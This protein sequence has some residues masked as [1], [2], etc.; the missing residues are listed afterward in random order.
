LEIVR[1]KKRVV[2][3]LSSIISA[4]III[5]IY[6]ILIDYTAYSQDQ[7]FPFLV[8]DH[9]N[10]KVELLTEGLSFPTSMAFIDK[11]NTLVLE[12]NSGSVRLISDGI[13]RQKPILTLHVDNKGERGL[14]GIA[15]LKDKIDNNEDDTRNNLEGVRSKDK[16]SSI[17]YVFLY[18][19]ESENATSTN[20]IYRYEWD[21]KSLTNPKLI[22]NFL[23]SPGLYH[24]GGKMLIGPRDNQLYVAIGDLNEPNSILQNYKDGK[25]SNYSSTIIRIDPKNGLPSIGNPFSHYSNSKNSDTIMDLDYCYAY[26][27]RN[28]FGIAS[29][30]V[31]GNLWETENGERTYDEIN[32][33]KPGFNSG[34]DKIMGPI[35]RNNNTSESELFQLNGSYYAD[36]KFSWRISIGVTA[37]EFLNSPNLGNKYENNI[38]IGDINNGNIYHFKLNNDDRAK[39]NLNYGEKSSQYSSLED[40][41]ADNKDEILETLFAT[42]FEGRITDIKTGPDGNLYVLTYFDGKIYKIKS[43]NEDLMT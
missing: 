29:D 1:H 36:P 43:N 39:L 34:W 28:S 30:P 3:L 22:L 8:G 7:H 9:K 14:L 23:S 6:F 33:V 12:K 31:T 42:N 27:L 24:N 41:V 32:L 25:R 10:L 17:T 37:I 15:V 5:V 38:F 18:L 13:L 35:S 16:P 40:L 20:K 11:N 19:T 21:G 2:F 26:G 4:P